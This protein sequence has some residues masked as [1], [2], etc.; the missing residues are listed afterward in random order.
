MIA[1][2]PKNHDVYGTPMTKI[3]LEVRDAS[4]NKPYAHLYFAIL[5]IYGFSSYA[6]A[7]VY[8]KFE[9]GQ[10]GIILMTNECPGDKTGQLKWA[11]SKF[12]SNLREGCYVINV[13]GNPVVKWQDGVMQELDG[14]LFSIDPSQ[15]IVKKELRPQSPTNG[16]VAQPRKP[17]NTWDN[18]KPLY[19]FAKGDKNCFAS[20]WGMLAAPWGNTLEVVEET[21]VVSNDGRSMKLVGKF[22]DRSTS[23]I[24]HYKTMEECNAALNHSSERTSSVKAQ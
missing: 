22:K 14:S 13:R 5:A 20:E 12:G 4:Q 7:D 10:D 24:Y 1:S 15:A 6:I 19:I 23:T 11:I 3:N 16:N 18:V 17:A 9:S 2:S 8:A 21:Q